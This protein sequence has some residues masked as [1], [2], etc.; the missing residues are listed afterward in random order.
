MTVAHDTLFDIGIKGDVASTKTRG[1]SET[2]VDS[3]HGYGHIM[4]EEVINMEFDTLGEARDGFRHR[5]WLE[6]SNRKQEHK[7]IT[8]CGCLVETRIKHNTANG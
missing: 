7:P 8:R 1:Q 5:K 3:S 2:V 4:V 6:K